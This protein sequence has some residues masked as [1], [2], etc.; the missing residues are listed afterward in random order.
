MAI[1][2][3]SELQAAVAKYHHRDDGS[4]PDHIAF[5]EKRINVR[6]SARFG[7][8]ESTL[9]GIVG[10]NTIPLPSGFISHKALWMTEYGNRLEIYYIDPVRMPVIYDSQGQPDYFTI[11]GANIVFNYPLAG[12]YQYVFRYKKGFAIASTLTNNVLTNYPGCY[13][14]G[15][16]REAA[17][18]SDD[19]T[20]AQKYELLFQ[21]SLEEAAKAEFENIA[22]ATLT[23][24]SAIV[25]SRRTNILAGDM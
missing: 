1:T 22:A 20:A 3:Y 19:D 16:L 21:Q 12:A 14:Y 10:T 25:G 13:L 15:A 9:N 2:N 17:I 6:L 5:A 7:E 11:D 4:I 18:L 23:M 8:V 24:D